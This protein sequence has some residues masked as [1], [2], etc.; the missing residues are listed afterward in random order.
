MIPLVSSVCYGPLNLCQLP[1]TWWKISLNSAGCLDNEYP[2]C[3]G[4]LDL[5][6]LQVLGLR[7]EAVVAFVH[8][9]RPDYLSFEKWVAENSSGVSK[10]DAEKWN[11]SVRIRVHRQEKLDDIYG[12]LGGAVCFNEEAVTSAMV[13]NRLEDWHLYCLRDIDAS[14]VKYWQGKVVPLISSL[15]TGPMGVLQ[16][17]RTWHKV[18][19][20]TAGL[21]HHDYPGCGNGLDRRVIEEALGLDRDQVVDYLTSANPGYLEFERW[22]R[23]QLGGRDVSESVTEFHH[24]LEGRIHA[25]E[26]RAEIHATLERNDDGSWMKGVLLN[27]LEDWHLAHAQLYR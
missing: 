20:E 18:Q 3:G 10:S 4:V 9:E 6:V 2:E 23:E 27:H 24:F 21:L 12:T 26:K 14:P 19:L 8:E 11:E 1:R 25:D 15:D 16:I 5:K 17:A 22:I 7:S 13:L